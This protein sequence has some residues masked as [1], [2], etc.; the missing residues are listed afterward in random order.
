[1][2]QGLE[3]EVKT[4]VK[5][6]GWAQALQTI[7]YQEWKEYFEGKI[8][9]KEVRDLIILHTKQ[10]AKRQITWWKSDKRIRWI[11][12]QPEA[13]KLVEKFLMMGQGK[14]LD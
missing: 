3:K 10:Y 8:S 5:K 7:G 11:K 9:R 2:R 4:L 14:K 1:M 13:E 12:K 6:C